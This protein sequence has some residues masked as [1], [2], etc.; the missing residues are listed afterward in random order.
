MQFGPATGARR[1][2]R[3]TVRL[4]RCVNTGS[5]LLRFCPVKR[6]KRRD[7]RAFPFHRLVSLAL[8]LSFAGCAPKEPRAG[9]VILNGAEPESLDPVIVT[10]VPEMRLVHSLFEGLVRLDP[11]TG[12][13]SPGLA[14][15][16][17][18]SANGRTYTFHL[19]S[20]AVWSTGEPIVADDVVYSWRRLLDPK[21]ASSYAGALYYVK[22]G[23]AFNRGSITNGAKV[24]V[25]ALNPRTVAV[26]LNSPT[27]FFVE[28]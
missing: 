19:R 2:R 17:E 4:P 26:E 18:Q 7:P 23:E 22:N 3:F 11:R 27:A 1:L 12:K 16:W 14:E 13:A 9:L 25:Q 28:L 10:G 15:S 5:N 6:R 24:G 8:C 20:N 21:T